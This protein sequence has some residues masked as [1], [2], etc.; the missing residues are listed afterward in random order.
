MAWFTIFIAA[1]VMW[2]VVYFLLPLWVFTLLV[3]IVL[4]AALAVFLSTLGG[5]EE[6]VRE[7]E[8]RMTPRGPAA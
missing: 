4:G 1:L 2:F 7:E 5:E 6:D 8:N 3:G